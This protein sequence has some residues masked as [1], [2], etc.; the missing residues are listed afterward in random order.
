VNPLVAEIGDSVPVRVFVTW[1]HPVVWPRSVL[2]SSC[3]DSVEHEPL[4]FGYDCHRGTH[5]QWRDQIRVAP[6]QSEHDGCRR[7]ELLDPRRDSHPDPFAI[8]RPLRSGRLLDDTPSRDPPHQYGRDGSSRP[9]S[10]S[11]NSL[12]CTSVLKCRRTRIW[13]WPP[14]VATIPGIVGSRNA[15]CRS[16]ALARGFADR[17]PLRWR[18]VGYHR[19]ETESCPEALQAAFQDAVPRRHC[20]MQARRRRPGR[21]VPAAVAVSVHARPRHHGALIDVAGRKSWQRRRGRARGP[22]ATPAQRNG[23]IGGC[24]WSRYDRADGGRDTGDR[25]DRDR[26]DARPGR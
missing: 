19:I 25:R 22:L 15:A 26:S 11:A 9:P 5:G 10:P 20:P 1:L 13:S 7:I 16:A 14:M 23:Q 8:G 4:G 17:S 6:V 3:I 21:P 12:P 18:A 2:R 24:A